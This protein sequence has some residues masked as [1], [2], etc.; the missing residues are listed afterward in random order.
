MPEQE[1]ILIV[2][3]NLNNL[4][5]LFDTLQDAGFRVLVAEDGQSALSVVQQER[6]DLILLDVRMPGLDGFETCRR[7]K[8]DAATV[9][10]PVIFMTALSE[11]MD[12]VK[13]LEMGA[14]DYVTKPVQV[15]TVLARV[16]THLTMTRLRVELEARVQDLEAALAKVKLLSG[17]LPICASC[18]KIRD[19]EGYWHQVEAYVRDHSEAEFSHGICPDCVKQLYPDL[20]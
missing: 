5:V 1:T 9:H 12:E 2:D 18:K 13:G 17:F 15:K 4:G 8:A 6:P 16:N 19:D 7:L 11:A 14:V 10:V 3:D 20:S